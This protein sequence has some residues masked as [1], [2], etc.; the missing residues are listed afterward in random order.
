MFERKKRKRRRLQTIEIKIFP[1]RC[2]TKNNFVALLLALRQEFV[3][4]AHLKSSEIKRAR[5]NRLPQN[6][7]G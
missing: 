2:K 7:T 5:A 1:S 3:N 6:H 4:F